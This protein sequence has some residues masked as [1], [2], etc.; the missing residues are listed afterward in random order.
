MTK[1]GEK[2]DSHGR[3]PS[4]GVH[5]VD[6]Q[7]GPL[8]GEGHLHRVLPFA[9][10]A[11]LS[12]IIAVPT[13]SWIRPG[14]AIAGTALTAATIVGSAMLPWHRLARRAQ[15]SMPSLLLI[16]TLLLAAASGSGIG[17]PFIVMSVLPMMWL[18]IYENR[19][20]V[21]V[22][23][24]IA[25]L[26]LWLGAPN[27]NPEPATGAIASIAVLMVCCAGMGVTLH[28]LVANARKLALDLSHQQLDLERNATALDALPDL[29]NRYRVRDHVITYHNAAWGDQYNVAPGAAVGRSLEEFLSDHEMDGMRSQLAL[30]GPDNPILMDNVAR[31]ASADSGVQW[32]EWMDRYLA[33]DDGAEV[34]SIGRDVTGRKNAERDLAE[35]ET[36]FRDLA[37]KSVDVVWRFS[38]VPTP[39]FEYMS[40]SVESI[41]GYPPS[42]FLEDFSRMSGILDE[43][44][45]TAIA[46][47]LNGEQVLD[48]FDF[49]FRHADGSIIV[50]ETRTTPLRDGL[51]GVSR[52]VT[53]LRRLQDNMAALALRDSL[54]GLANRRLFNELLDA[55]LARTQRSRAPLALAFLDL[56]GFKS[57]ND[58]HGHDAGDFVLCETARRLQ[59]VVR[60]A[61]VIARL[62]GDEFVIVFEPDDTNSHH[63]IERINQTLSQPI[64]ITASTAVVCTASIGV[65]DS[66]KVGYDATALLA[67]ADEAM[68]E[69]KRA[70]QA[71][72]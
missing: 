41:L 19:A 36:R 64:N 30:L 23:A 24:T 61:D 49:R 52:D 45:T 12:M 62:G 8:V 9:A 2:T 18:A 55:A 44:G 67:A 16:G 25:G 57:V 69:A 70:R 17:S 3:I 27:G 50:G 22:A 10:T 38:T 42:Y 15:L 59:K 71:A 26:A 5:V 31:A 35:S 28:E 7:Q 48:R 56:D 43:A 34:L 72:R 53:E 66:N 20:A 60:D 14:L 32:L 46:R 37:D 39:H 65:T 29:V 4:R 47:A 51:Q 40:P 13:T 54:T 58:L 1:M 21:V 68:Y 6:A 11:A 33:G 63:L